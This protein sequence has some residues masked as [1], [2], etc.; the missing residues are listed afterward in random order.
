MRMLGS[1]PCSTTTTRTVAALVVLQ[2][3]LRASRHSCKYTT[4]LQQACVSQKTAG[5]PAGAADWMLKHTCIGDVVTI[6]MVQPT[7]EQEAAAFHL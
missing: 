5:N 7:P 6:F 3:I 1:K 2:V 4:G